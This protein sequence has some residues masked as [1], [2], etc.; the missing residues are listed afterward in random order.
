MSMDSYQRVGG[1]L[2]EIYRAS[3]VVPVNEFKQWAYDFLQEIIQFDS[4]LW[5]SGSS[6]KRINIHSRFLYNQPAEML[7][8]YEENLNQ[9]DWRRHAVLSSP[10][11]SVNAYDL[12]SIE[13]LVA[14]PAYDHIKKYGIEQTLSTCLLDD[15][16]GLFNFI[17]FYRKDYENHFTRVDQQLK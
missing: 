11:R 14:M 12:I 15:I 10:G 7:E 9:D 17:S 13:Q 3:R 16:G 1:V 6:G 5:A 2:L 8:N 4:G